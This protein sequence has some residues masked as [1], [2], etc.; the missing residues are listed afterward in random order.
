M[1]NPNFYFFL[2]KRFEFSSFC[3][4]LWFFNGDL[5]ARRGKSTFGGLVS[6]YFV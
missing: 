6:K 3:L 1:V 4:D 2:V 5:S